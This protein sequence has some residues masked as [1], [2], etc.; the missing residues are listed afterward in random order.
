VTGQAPALSSR[1]TENILIIKLGALGDVVLCLPQ[2]AHILEAHPQAGVTVLTAPGYVELFSGLPRLRVVSFRRK[3]LFEMLRL[4]V[5]LSR[6]SF[7]VVYDLQGSLRSRCMT[8]LTRAPRR[9][10]RHSGVAYTHAPAPGTAAVHAFDRFNAVLAAGGIGAAPPGFQSAWSAAATPAVS[11]WLQEQDLQGKQLV[12]LHAGS[13]PR[14]PSKRWEANAFLEL[15]SRLSARGFVVVWTGADAERDLNRQLSATVG[16]DATGRF[17]YLELA[18]LARHAVF[19]I[20]ND[21]G[22]MHLFSMAGLPVYAF[23]GPTDWR[24]SHAL[25]QEGRVLTNP[26]PC[27][28]CYRPVCPPRYRHACLRMITPDMVIERLEKDGLLDGIK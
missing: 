2:V 7:A 24:R 28:P 9:V 27:S 3:G 13:G 18:A 17:G 15:A 14:W 6:R 12:L 5:W 8:L 11:A 22:P 21:S 25:G 4:L 19:A 26:Q 16:I 20:T 1:D 23:F 10:G